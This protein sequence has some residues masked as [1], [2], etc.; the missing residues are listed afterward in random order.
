MF[1]LGHFSHI[2]PIFVGILLAEPA[3]Q[4]YVVK[5]RIFPSEY[6]LTQNS[7]PNVC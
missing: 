7:S 4:L 1:Y 5:S 6:P 3:N 2:V